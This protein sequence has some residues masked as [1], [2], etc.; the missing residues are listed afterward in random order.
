MKQVREILNNIQNAKLIVVSKS[1]CLKEIQPFY[2]LG[3]RNF[4]ENRVQELLAKYDKLANVNWHFIGQLQSN[5]VKY[6]IGKVALIQSLNS[7]KLA[8]TINKESYKLNTFTNCLIQ[9]K[10]EDDPNR[11]GIKLGEVDDFYEYCQTLKNLKIKGFM[12]VPPNDKPPEDYFMKAKNLFEKYSRIDDNIEHLS[13]GMS[14]DYLIA[15]ECGSNMLRIGSK[16]F[17]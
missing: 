8:D 11:G 16:L 10:F 6:L 1:R 12:V 17:E 3:L 15:L 14:E 5:K 9:L 7:I 2:D 4:G 13:M